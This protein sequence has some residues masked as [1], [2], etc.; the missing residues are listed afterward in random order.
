MNYG[1]TEYVYTYYASDDSNIPLFMTKVEVVAFT[2]QGAEA[3][4]ARAWGSQPK[5]V[6]LE[7]ITTA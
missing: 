1:R 4:V 6:K 5:H 7:K 2:R 3:A